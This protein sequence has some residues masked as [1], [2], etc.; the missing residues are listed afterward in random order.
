M[1]NVDLNAKIPNNVDL[2][3]D[4]RLLRALEQWQPSYLDW[5]REM[6]PTDYNEK[7]VWLRTAVSVDAEGWAQIDYVKMPDY[8]WGIFLADAVSYRTIGYGDVMGQLAWQVVPGEHRNTLRRLIV[9]QGDTEPASVEQQRLLGHKAPSLY[10]LRNLFQVNVEEGRHLWAMVYLLHSQFGRDGREEAEELLQRRSGNADKPR[11]L[12]AFNAPVENWLDFFMFTMFTD[13]DGK[14]QLLALAESGFDPLSRTTRF[15]LTEEAHHMFVGETGVERI[16]QRTAE[17]MKQDPNEDVRNQGGIPLDIVQKHLNLWF[18]L[19][20]DL[21]GGE[22]SSN[23]ASF[24]AAGLKGRYKE[25]S[26]AEHSALNEIY[27]MPVVKDGV[28]T[29]DE[30][31]LRN[32]M[33]EVLRDAYVDDCQRGVDRWNKRLEEAGLPQR[34]RLPSKRFYRHIGLYADMPFD[35]EGRLLDRQEW[36]RRRDDWLPAEADKAYVASLQKPVREPGQIANWLGKPARG[37][38]GL[39]FEY[40]YVRLD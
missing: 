38:K 16:V 24:F 15:M 19:S 30:V 29:D 27:K 22:I 35:P 23:A 11:I 14:Y 28:V 6:G 1:S 37:I 4:K 36:E 2:G 33:N 8:R 3:Q 10:D 26:Y 17:L 5:W 7:D 25:D 12:G 39:P 31:P 32:A 34:L 18:A 40:E 13:R 9:T 21:F 20:L